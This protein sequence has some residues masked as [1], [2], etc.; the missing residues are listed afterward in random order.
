[1]S[2]K[3][4]NDSVKSNDFVFILFVFNVYLR[5]IDMNA[6]SFTFTQRTIAMRKTMNEMRKIHATRQI[7][8]VFNI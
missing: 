7:N 8:D 4:F 6:L 2:F 1:M 3:I 5:M